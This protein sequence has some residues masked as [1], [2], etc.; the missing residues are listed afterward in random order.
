MVSYN[1]LPLCGAILGAALPGEPLGM[2]HYCFGG[3]IIAGG[4]WG[5][6]GKENRRH[7]ER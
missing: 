2:I 1:I 3:L 6:L 4:L 5:T 7:K